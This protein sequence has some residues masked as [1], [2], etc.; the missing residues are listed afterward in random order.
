MMT[1]TQQQT[2]TS[3]KRATPRAQTTPAT[4]TRA[5][6]YVSAAV[7]GDLCQLD[8]MIDA[9]DQFVRRQSGL[10]ELV[11]TLSS[12]RSHLQTLPVVWHRPVLN[13]WTSLEII[14]TETRSQ[15]RALTEMELRFVLALSYELKD[16]VVSARRQI[17]EPLSGLP[18]P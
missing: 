3:P 12:A 13:L 8:R 17:A 2:V 14:H 7:E 9:I 18:T 1:F 16:K 5:S 6:A 15:N 10:G 11:S 4:P